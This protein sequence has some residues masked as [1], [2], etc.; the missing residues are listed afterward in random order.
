[1][2]RELQAQ[3]RSSSAIPEDPQDNE[4]Q[5]IAL[6]FDLHGHSTQ[7]NSFL[8]GTQAGPAGRVGI[9][10]FP[11][12]FADIYDGFSYDQSRFSMGKNKQSTG[13]VV[14]SCELGIKRAYT[15]ESSLG[16][17]SLGRLVGKQYS[18]ADYMDLGHSLCAVTLAAFGPNRTRWLNT[19]T[20]LEEEEALRLARDANNTV[21]KSNFRTLSAV[22]RDASDFVNR[23]PSP[24]PASCKSELTFLD[25]DE[26]QST[27]EHF[28]TN[29]STPLSCA[30]QKSPPSSASLSPAH[31]AN[32]EK[33]SLASAT[34][35][36]HR[37]VSNLLR[38]ADA[39][40]ASSSEVVSA[41]S[42]L[43][44]AQPMQTVVVNSDTIHFVEPRGSDEIDEDCERIEE[45]G[46]KCSARYDQVE[47]TVLLPIPKANHEYIIST[48]EAEQKR[49]MGE[50][51]TRMLTHEP[52][53]HEKTTKMEEKRQHMCCD[54]IAVVG[55]VVAV[56]VGA[57]C[58]W[59]RAP[60][61]AVKQG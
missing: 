59:F 18:S 33:Q 22:L 51:E 60:K 34:A 29:A 27:W 40:L 28:C 43:Q 56:A 52:N 48:Q 55:V 46:S 8:Y 23:I 35:C 6:F 37:S 1:M 54:K 47:R 16:G 12:L 44:G 21:T 58:T 11:K 5:G 42:P 13:R 4:G 61:V 31:D 3:P 10:V 45:T 41:E 26:S 24:S 30:I 7:L 20:E 39:W 53:T 50:G 17:A 25:E 57:A 2:L 32:Q 38:D 15:L 49:E 14:A 19:Q 9:R 36:G